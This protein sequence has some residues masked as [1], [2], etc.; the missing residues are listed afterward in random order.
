MLLASCCEVMPSARARSW[1][2]SMRMALARLVPVVVDVARVGVLAE[3][4]REGL[5]QLARRAGIGAADAELQRPADRRPELQRAHARQHVVEVVGE[6]LLQARLHAGALLE[7]LGDDH[8][9]G[10]EVVGELGVERQVEA[11]GAL[12]DVEAPVLDVGV[13]LQQL[14]DPGDDLLRRLERGALRQRQIDQQLGPVGG[15]EELLL[16]E[17]HADEREHEQARG[18][19]QHAPLV[20]QRQIEG[21]V[22]PAREARGRRARRGPRACRAG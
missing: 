9:L 20:A 11:D 18:R 1:S 22:E 3:H 8:G 6:G 16:H 10:E 19:R 4:L 2:T 17:A 12:A 13:G 7:A 15:R 21:A 5:R 14:L